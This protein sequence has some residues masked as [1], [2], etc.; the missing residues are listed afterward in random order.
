M[1]A[2]VTALWS[3][4]KLSTMARGSTASSVVRVISTRLQVERMTASLTPARDFKSARAAGSV[5]SRKARHSRTST[6]AV[7]WLTPV[8]S[9]F[10]SAGG[11]PAARVW[12]APPRRDPQA[13]HG[14]VGSPGEERNC[15]LRLADPIR[16]QFDE[17]PGGAGDHGESNQHE[18]DGHELGHQLVERAQGGQPVIEFVRL[19]G[20]ELAFLEEIEQGSHR[21]KQQRRIPQQYQHD[22]HGEPGGAHDGAAPGAHRIPQGGH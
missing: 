2:E 9:S 15:Y 12:P 19:L 8:I 14:E 11:F 18:A 13:H 3:A 6:C 21:G 20:L 16:L 1:A 22:M 7:L 10:I 5:S 4:R 17:C